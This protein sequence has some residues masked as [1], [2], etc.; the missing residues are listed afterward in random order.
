MCYVAGDEATVCHDCFSSLKHK[1]IP[2]LSLV[3]LD[4]GRVPA[5][6]PHLTFCEQLLLA[7]ARGMRHVVVMKRCNRGSY[8]HEHFRGHVTAYANPGVPAKICATFPISPSS[9]PE[10]V[11]VVFTTP[12][13]TDAEVRAKLQKSKMWQVRSM[14]ECCSLK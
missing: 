1:V 9:L 11:N 4:T 3:R 5:H 2:N 13:T 7:P 6:L 12:C 10:Y 8:A 14:C